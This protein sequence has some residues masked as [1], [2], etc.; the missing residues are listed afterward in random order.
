[1]TF[2]EDDDDEDGEY[3]SP[4]QEAEMLAS[5]REILAR[6]RAPAKLIKLSG[7]SRAELRRMLWGDKG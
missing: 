1:M 2:S 7:L 4:E 5:M 6:S 3:L